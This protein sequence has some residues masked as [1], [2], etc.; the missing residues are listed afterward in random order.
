M[1]EEVVAAA[2]GE[3][4]VD[5]RDRGAVAAAAACAP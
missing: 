4:G 5:G 2:T 3:A 1:T